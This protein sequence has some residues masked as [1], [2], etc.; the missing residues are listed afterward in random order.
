M[1][2][3]W[4]ES[5]VNRYRSF[6]IAASIF[7][8]ISGLI[9]L[10][11]YLIFRDA[12]HIYIYLV[13][14][15]AFLPLEVFL[16]VIVLERILVRREKQGMLQKLNMVVGAFFSEVGTRLLGNLLCC[17]ESRDRICQRL[18]V[19]QDWGSSDFRK[20]M[21]FARTIRGADCGSLNLQE[22]REFLIQKRPFLLRLLENPNLLEHE[23]FT[24]LLWAIFHLAEELEARPSMEG[25]PESDLAHIEGDIQR[26]YGQLA[27]EWV[28][29]VEHLKRNYP[30]LFSLVLRTHPLQESPSAVVK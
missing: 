8:A 10:V 27:A 11:H 24:D 6:L 28:A 14:D 16:V 26:L 19:S 22:L 7:L 21:A 23:R 1:D 20:A 13:G 9:Y 17:F 2:A 4:L 3:P 25:L 30:F 15:L 12:H 18:A 29:Y 5:N